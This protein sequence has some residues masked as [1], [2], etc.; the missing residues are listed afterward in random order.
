MINTLRNENIL[1]KNDIHNKDNEIRNYVIDIIP[2]LNS[3]INTLRLDNSSLE[4]LVRVNQYFS[5]EFLRMFL[6]N[7]RI[8]LEILKI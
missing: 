6:A 1:L 2:K 3:E 8:G 4:S 7:Y 5:K